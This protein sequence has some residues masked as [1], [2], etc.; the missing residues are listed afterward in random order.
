MRTRNVQEPHQG[1]VEIG[2]IDRIDNDFICAGGRDRE[3]LL[4]PLSSF[5]S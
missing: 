4:K 3:R 2:S 1:G 5:L